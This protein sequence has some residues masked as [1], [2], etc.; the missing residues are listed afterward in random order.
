MKDVKRALS[1]KK[2]MS[3][4]DVKQLLPP[5]YQDFLDVFSRDLA[6]RLPPHR[7]SDYKIPLIPGEQPR[8]GA[9]YSMSQNE[10]EVMAKY[11]KDNLKNEFISPSCS[12]A[13]SPVLFVKKP[14]P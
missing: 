12:P 4:R 13:S 9:L 6:E 7:P 11:L 2:R 3:S 5:E 8:A 10:L 1:S 14:G